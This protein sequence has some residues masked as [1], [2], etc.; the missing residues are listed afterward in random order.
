MAPR[1]VLMKTD[2]KTVNTG[3]HVNT[4][5]SVNTGRPFSTA[6]GCS[7]HMTRN[8]AHLS[9]FKDFDEGYVTFGGGAHGGRIT[10]KGTIKTDNLDFDDV[11]FVK[12]LKFNLFS[13]SQI[14]DK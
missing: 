8:I 2:L 12:E 11:Y 9:E 5:R 13:V 6:S 1:A 10:G 14:C 4:I 3:R 7:R